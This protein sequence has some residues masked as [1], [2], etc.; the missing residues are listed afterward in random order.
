M[1]RWIGQVLLVV[2]LG[3]ASTVSG[4]RR[5]N[6][7]SHHNDDE[8]MESSFQLALRS[9]GL[10]GV[11]YVPFNTSSSK[12][13]RARPPFPL[14]TCAL[15]IQHELRHVSLACSQHREHLLA[16]KR[17]SYRLL[18]EET[19]AVSEESDM[20][21]GLSTCISHDECDATSYCDKDQRCW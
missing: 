12:M 1:G 15:R 16:E 18:A 4:L 2:L 17:A 6:V 19:V 13:V 11:V 7:E 14:C 20:L 5:G 10:E 8:G 3:P 21:K 9:M